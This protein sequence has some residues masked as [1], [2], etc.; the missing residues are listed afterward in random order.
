MKSSAILVA[1]LASGCTT[2]TGL[3]YTPTIPPIARSTPAISAVTVDD[4]R[5]EKDPT[6][7]G[8]IRGGFGNPLKTLT[9][10]RPIAAEVQAAF[11]AA[12]TARGL[13]GNRGPDTLS[14]HVMKLSAKQY[15]RRDATAAFAVTVH[16]AGGQSVYSDTVDVNKVNGSIVTFD[17]GVFASTEDLHAIMVQT[18][19]EAID[20]VLDK[21]GFLAAVEPGS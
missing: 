14:V 16:D 6:Y 7:I 9:T 21:P 5:S 18:M 20:Q 12:L 1:L 13:L 11:E 15:V 8:A 3:P 19:S 4:A 10:A 17:A 2:A